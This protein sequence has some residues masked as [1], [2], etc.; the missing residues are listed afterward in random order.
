V[1]AGFLGL[2]HFAGLSAQLAIGAATWAVL[3]ASCVR[4]DAD[5][6][7]RVALVVLVATSAEILGSVILGAY[8]YRLENLPAFV[9]PGHGLVYLGGLAISQSGV[10]RRHRRAFLVSVGAVVA[11]WA[12]AGLILLGRTDVLGALTG[13]LL[14]YVLVR[15]RAPTLY[16]GVFLIVAF[17]EIYG[18]SIGAWQ[19]AET[20]PGTPLPAG[21]PPSGIASVYVLFDIAAIALAPRLL[22]GFST[23]RRLP[24]LARFANAA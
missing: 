6:R 4:L 12:G 15:G 10:V 23:L 11:A 3:F 13:A 7:A 1:I 8:T 9:P 16:A 2:D 14:L 18:T 19:W 22:T 5:Q 20:A 24:P 21:N 17:L